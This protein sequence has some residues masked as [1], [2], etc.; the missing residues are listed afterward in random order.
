MKPELKARYTEW[1]PWAMDVPVG[2]KTVFVGVLK[3]VFEAL[4]YSLNY[5]FQ[6][7][8]QEDHQ[9][10][11]LQ[12]DGSYSGM[13]G[14]LVREEIDIAGP[15]VVSEQ[16][17]IVAEFTTFLESSS[18]GIITGI[19][20][21]DRNI[22][23]YAKVFSWQVWLTLLMTIISGAFVADLIN[24]V[25]GN[26]CDQTLSLRRYLWVFSSFLISH[27]AGSQTH[28]AL[29]HV[30][31][32][33]SFRILL[34]FWLLG[35][36]INCIF[37]FQ[38]SV[39]STF[40]ITRLEPV[41]SNLAELSK[42]VKITPVTTRGSAVQICFRSSPDHADLWKRME[43]NS[44][45]FSSETVAE[46]M[47]KVERGSHILIV[48]YIYALNIANDYVKTTAR[49]TVQVEQVDFCQSYIALAL[50]KG[51][52]AKILRRINSK[53]IYIIQAKLLDRWM[54][55]VHANYTH[56]TREIPDKSKALSLTDIL[57]GFA[58]WGTGIAISLLLLVIEIFGRKRQE[59]S[60]KEIYVASIPSMTSLNKD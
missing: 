4:S 53:L 7:E 48:D 15:F 30:W 10:G 60:K 6:I 43:N 36:V 20:S 51:A 31:Y 40:A 45:Q 5:K 38:G 27:D 18:L 25:S 34:A 46:T 57:G 13:L 32:L 56:C 1:P 2:N 54:N 9:F 44:I 21:D 59:K 39:T 26:G 37:S 42:K 50:K 12:K 17:A 33:H 3:D 58:I 49:C 35:P 16:R 55:R 28:R 29:K 41:I 23:L 22:F 19:K 24:H 11:S 52:S 14:A 8:S 47:L